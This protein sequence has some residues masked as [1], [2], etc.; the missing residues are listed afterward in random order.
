MGNKL[1]ALASTGQGAGKFIAN[2]FA[3]ILGTVASLADFLSVVQA[4]WQTLRSVASFTIGGIV[5]GPERLPSGLHHAEEIG[6][7][8]DGWQTLRSVASFTIGGIVDG[9][10]YVL[11]AL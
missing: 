1:T 3:T 5:D 10:G 7:A 11:D 2:G 4:G 9:I 8:G 6:E